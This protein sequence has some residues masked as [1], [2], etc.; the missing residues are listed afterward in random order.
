VF[1]LLRRDDFLTNRVNCVGCT[2]A[3]G[4]P[5]RRSA[6]NFAALALVWLGGWALGAKE[7]AVAP[8][9]HANPPCLR[10]TGGLLRHN[11]LGDCGEDT[12]RCEAGV[13]RG[14]RRRGRLVKVGGQ[15]KPGHV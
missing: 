14:A 2:H 1:L 15:P 4:P 3:G 7:Q 8:K 6:G 13:R 12:W 9:L 11:L 5:A 10:L